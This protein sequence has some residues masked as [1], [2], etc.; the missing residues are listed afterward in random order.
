ML[1]H[2]DNDDDDIKELFQQVFKPLWN[3]VPLVSEGIMVSKSIIILNVS[4][5]Y[6]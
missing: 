6:S 4:L 2:T 3:T 5:Y 1:L